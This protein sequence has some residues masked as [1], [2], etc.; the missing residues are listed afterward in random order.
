MSA[1]P[2]CVQTVLGSI[3]PELLG[4]T[5]MHE[6]VLCDLTVPELSAQQLPEVEIRLDNVFEIRH[7]WC[8]HYGN[9]V[10]DDRDLAVDELL[11]YRTAGGSALVELTCE[12][13]APDA[14][15]LADIARRTGLHI[16]A[17]CGPYVEAHLT[18]EQRAR[19]IDQVSEA[20]VRAFSDGIDDSGVRAGILGEIGLSTPCTAVERRSLVAA[21]L[22]QSETGAAINVHPPRTLQGT[23]DAIEVLADAGADLARVVISHVDRTL[24]SVGDMQ[25]VADTGVVLE[26]DFFGI[27]S[28]Y[29]P[30]AD[31][32][33]PNDGQ[34]V[35]LIAELVRLG[36]V[37][38]I[39]VSQDICTRTRLRRYGGHGYA[40]LLENAVPLMGRRGLEQD[41]IDRILVRTPRRLLT[42]K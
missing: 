8:R 15:G 33:L 23:L 7:H 9:H 4:A 10:L 29:Y 11:R 20:M 21:A 17:G 37:D 34:R 31:V 36:Y 18:G 25:R 38:Q 12:G 28:A 2:G 6:H 3:A 30:F 13:I 16:V 24:F 35:R 14:R 19:S 32:D 22:A 41:D 26:F 42:L 27:E 1:A 39:V 40:H 5:L